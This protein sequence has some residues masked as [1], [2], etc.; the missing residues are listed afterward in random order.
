MLFPI[1]AI[2]FFAVVSIQASQHVKP[3]T[4]TLFGPPADYIV[5]RTLYARTLR[6]ADDSNVILATWENYS[7]EPPLVHF[8]VYRSTDFGQTWTHVSNITDDVNGWGLRYQP[9]LY[10]MTENIGTF[11]AGDY[12]ILETL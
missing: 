10:E 5:P 3:F 11:Q 6:L 1:A 7:P 8:P 12:L 4:A 2:L 9:F